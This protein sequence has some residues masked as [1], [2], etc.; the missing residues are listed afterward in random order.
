MVPENGFQNHLQGRVRE[1]YPPSKNTVFQFCRC[2]FLSIQTLLQTAKGCWAPEDRRIL[3][4]GCCAMACKLI[5]PCT[6]DTCHAIGSSKSNLSPPWPRIV[7]KGLFQAVAFFCNCLG[8]GKNGTLLNA[9]PFN[10]K[11]NDDF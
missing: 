4:I 11:S 9:V 5:L 2:S 3:R 8:L 10:L 6:G 1:A 7:M